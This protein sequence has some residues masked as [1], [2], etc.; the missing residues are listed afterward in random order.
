MI[1]LKI[2][3]I[4]FASVLNLNCECTNL[5]FLSPIQFNPFDCISI[6][7]TSSMLPERAFQS[8]CIRVYV[9][10]TSANH[11]ELLEISIVRKTI[12]FFSAFPWIFLSKYFCLDDC[13]CIRWWFTLKTKSYISK[14]NNFLY[15]PFHRIL[16]ALL[17]ETIAA[18]A[19]DGEKIYAE[20]R[21]YFEG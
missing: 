15:K 12:S 11:S 16:H 13:S 9:A 7:N 3:C 4:I 6:V 2:C 1:W 5:L 14:C 21:V 17:N 20:M 18:A 19:D 8:H 10:R